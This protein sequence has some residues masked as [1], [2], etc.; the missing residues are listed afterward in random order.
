MN[1]LSIILPLYNETKRL[2]A[3]MVRLVNYRPHAP[4][5]YELLLVDN[6]STD[7]TFEMCRQYG[8]RYDWVYPLRIDIKGKGAAVRFGVQMSHSDLI[9]TADADLATPLAELPRFLEAIQHADIVCG[10]RTSYVESLVRRSTHRTFAAIA[11]QMT[12]IHDTQCGFKLYRADVA[13]QLFAQAT[14]DGF[15]FD[16]E[17]LHLA[18]KAGYAVRE[19]P[20]EWHNDQQYSTVSPGVDSFKMLRDLVSIPARHVHHPVS[21]VSEHQPG[22]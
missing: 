11:W 13:H 21:K 16:V 10:Q 22:D 6:A 14:V 3:A 15:A 4:L 8:E 5:P 1:S 9:Y 2:P 17:I 18:K 7:S 12:G 19:L 20:V